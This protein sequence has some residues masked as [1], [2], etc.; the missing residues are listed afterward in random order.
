M[1][2]GEYDKFLETDF[3]EVSSCREGQDISVYVE[4]VF[5]LQHFTI[6]ESIGKEENLV[7]KAT[8][9]YFS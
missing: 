3:N 1:L 9:I 6:Y 4:I 8:P 2:P 5:R 7:E